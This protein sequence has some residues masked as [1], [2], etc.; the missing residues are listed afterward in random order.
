MFAVIESNKNQL[1]VSEGKKYKID[2]LEGVIK[3]N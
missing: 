2:L 3:E 1:K